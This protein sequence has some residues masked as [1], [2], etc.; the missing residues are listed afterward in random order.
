MI[1]LPDRTTTDEQVVTHMWNSSDR[2]QLVT[3]GPDA[4]CPSCGYPERH[5]I[6]EDIGETLA[7]KLVA[8]GCPS[9]EQSRMPAE[10]ATNLC[11]EC[12]DGKCRN[13]IGEALNDAD[14]LVPCG[15]AHH[16]DGSL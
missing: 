5:R 10:P 3:D 14:E 11:P 13:C 15:C 6:Y 2:Y 9:C 16:A 7:L 1:Q 12:R 4:N 8:D